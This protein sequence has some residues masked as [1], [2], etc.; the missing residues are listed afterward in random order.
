MEEIRNLFGELQRIQ[1]RC[2]P[3]GLAV[4]TI[5]AILD[6]CKFNGT[7]TYNANNNNLTISN[8]NNSLTLKPPPQMLMLGAA[9]QSTSATTTTL[10]VHGN[11]SIQAPTDQTQLTSRVNKATGTADDNIS[12]YI[13]DSHTGCL[14][15]NQSTCEPN[16]THMLQAHLGGRELTELAVES[17]RGQIPVHRDDNERSISQ[18]RKCLQNCPVVSSSSAASSAGDLL[19]AQHPNC[20][21]HQYSQQQQ[22]YVDYDDMA[23]ENINADTRS[24]DLD[25]ANLQ[26]ECMC[27]SDSIVSSPNE[28][29]YKCLRD[30]ASSS[31]GDLD[32][33]WGLSGGST[34]N[35]SMQNT[36]TEKNNSGRAP[37]TSMDPE[38][39]LEQEVAAVV[40]YGGGTGGSDLP[41][42]PTGCYS[43][44]IGDDK[45]ARSGNCCQLSAKSRNCDVVASA[46]AVLSKKLLVQKQKSLGT[47]TSVRDEGLGRAT[48]RTCFKAVS[49][50][51]QRTNEGIGLK[52]SPIKSTFRKAKDKEKYLE[53]K[54]MNSRDN[55]PSCSQREDCS[56]FAV[57]ATTA[58]NDGEEIGR[59]TGGRHSPTNG[60]S[61]M[62]SHT[63]RKEPVTRKFNVI[64][65]DHKSGYELDTGTEGE[66]LN[67]D[68]PVY[69]RQD[70][71]SESISSKRVLEENDAR[72]LVV[73]EE[74]GK[75]SS[76]VVPQGDDDGGDRDREWGQSKELLNDDGESCRQ[77]HA[78]DEKGEVLVDQV[79]VSG[80]L[81]ETSSG[82][83]KMSKSVIE[84]E[85]E[86]SVG[87]ALPS[88]T[89]TDRKEEIDLPGEDGGVNSDVEQK[90]GEEQ[91]R[92]NSGNKTKKINNSR[93]S[94]DA[95]LVLDL[96][97]KSKYTKE[98]SV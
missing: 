32:K 2:P 51:G 53:Q 71:S 87:D 74:I 31:G 57:V 42:P 13:I 91:E 60:R 10:G 37:H 9:P 54:E 15:N 97:D 82:D 12:G 75:K 96:N 39:M 85:Y 66:R 11:N 67:L 50:G 47:M 4:A 27:S 7:A 81:L 22:C 5:A 92:N 68:D 24:S 72:L 21:L 95:K 40:S 14:A 23:E 69:L 93:N 52:L 41:C 77:T 80:E 20:N 3:R 78:P 63:K 26:L 73:E 48:K 38:E 70:K 94:P 44:N 76:D 34:S 28:S 55:R 1:E 58:E 65:T 43:H 19:L 36:G 8:I 18:L 6:S 17:R 25:F 98:V 79:S 56:S 29:T 90:E 84:T 45:L 62:L 86:K 64:D 89:V 88:T 46:S 59:P 61:G 49:C 30:R 35:N 16:G 83:V 33:K